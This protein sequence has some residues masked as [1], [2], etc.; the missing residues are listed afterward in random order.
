MM[1]LLNISGNISRISGPTVFT[2]IYAYYGPKILILIMDVGL[3]ISLLL[4]VTF[5]RRLIPYRDYIKSL[6]DR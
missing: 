6:K 3:F 4:S 1:S 2:T 5:Y